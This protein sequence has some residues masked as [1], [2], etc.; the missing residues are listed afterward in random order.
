MSFDKLLRPRE[1]RAKKED[2]SVSD[3]SWQLLSSSGKNAPPGTRT[4]DPLIKS[5]QS[6]FENKGVMESCSASDSAQLRKLAETIVR[7]TPEQRQILT[8]L[9]KALDEARTQG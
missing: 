9:V 7:L 5:Q 2:L 6:G 4:P 8:D 3:K 1:L